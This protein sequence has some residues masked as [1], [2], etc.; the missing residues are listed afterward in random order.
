MIKNYWD[1]EKKENTRKTSS[2]INNNMSHDGSKINTKKKCN[3]PNQ[4]NKF[5]TLPYIGL[6][7]NLDLLKNIIFKIP[8]TRDLYQ[9]LSKINQSSFFGD[10]KPNLS[11]KNQIYSIKIS[12]GC[13]HQCTSLGRM[14]D[15]GQLISKPLNQCVDDFKKGLNKGH[16]QFNLIA[17]DIGPYGFDIGTSLPELLDEITK[18]NGNYQITIAETHPAW[19]I[20][21][22]D[23]LIPIIK[24]KKIKSLLLAIQ[25]G[26]DRILHLMRRSYNRNALISTVSKIKQAD[27]N[28][29]LDVQC[30]VGFPSETRREFMDTIKLINTVR[31]DSGHI[32][33]YIPVNNTDATKISPQIPPI[34]KRQR[35]RIA[36]KTLQK[37][38]FSVVYDRAFKC[39]SF[40]VKQTTIL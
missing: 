4:D 31:F 12:Q 36:V 28:L 30:I 18:I 26:N 13:I 21:Y 5:I 8:F 19:I 16:I 2:E 23:E 3:I 11:Q 32:F 35:S 6:G 40:N 17:D 37:N 22:I 24:R 25:S 33:T 39:L 20:K 34:E 27:P 14:I 10:S 1:A 9:N 29:L 15:V 38:G 7:T